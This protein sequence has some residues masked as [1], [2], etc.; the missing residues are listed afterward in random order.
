MKLAKIQ[1]LFFIAAITALISILNAVP[2]N[3]MGGGEDGAG[4]T[5]DASNGSSDF[6]KKNNGKT[7]TVSGIVRMTGS[8]PFTE[9]V[10]SDD[11]G[12]W[13]IGKD[14]QDKLARYEGQTVTVT[15]KAEY[16]NLELANGEPLGLRRA[17]T[18]IKIKR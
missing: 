9:I 10:I 8:M 2:L 13:F 11:D 7:V 6:M 12:D 4:N 5:G 18:N 3:A 14:E 17:L 16:T 15:G 1:S